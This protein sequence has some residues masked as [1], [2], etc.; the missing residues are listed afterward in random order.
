M[1]SFSI[2]EERETCN[3]DARQ[4]SGV[5]P[6]AR[7]ASST[8]VVATRCRPENGVVRATMMDAAARRRTRTSRDG[9]GRGRGRGHG[10]GRQLIACRHA[11]RSI[12]TSTD[13]PRANERER[14]RGR[15]KSRDDAR[16]ARPRW[17][18]VSRLSSND[19][20]DGR[21]HSLVMQDVDGAAHRARSVGQRGESGRVARQRRGWNAQVGY[22]RQ[23]RREL[24]SGVR[25]RQRAVRQGELNE[26]ERTRGR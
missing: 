21:G 25:R 12:Q 9:R 10:H 8:Y 5:S 16:R 4:A 7:R 13:V 6:F 11:T 26:T 2:T 22:R 18:R 19:E 24:E 20:D 15:E 3:I 23:M 1:R 14:E 17:T